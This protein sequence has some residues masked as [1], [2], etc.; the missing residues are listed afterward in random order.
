MIDELG[1]AGVEENR[2][3]NREDFLQ[4]FEQVRE[5]TM[6]VVRTI[7]EDKME[8]TCREGEWTFGDLARHIA[9]T[10]RYVFAE[11]ARGL[12]SRYKGC[13]R[14]LAAGRDGVIAFMERM[15]GESMEIFRG[16]T[17]EDFLKKGM[18]PEGKPVTA[19]R[20]LR[21]MVEH[22]AHHRGQMY[23]YLGILGVP[24]HP[25]YTLNEPQLRGLSV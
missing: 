4:H 14:E 3:M 23:V 22:E 1:K 19:W 12:P 21:A 25:L 11:C 13:G 18:S 9:A 20:L 2:V 16:M 15:H 7:P 8:W 10:E 6:R 5:R 24:A 17:E